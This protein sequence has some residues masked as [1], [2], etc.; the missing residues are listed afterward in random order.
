[1]SATFD[2]SQVAPWLYWSLFPIHR[3]FMRLY[4][5]QITVQGWEHLPRQGP[6]VFAVKHFSRWDPLVISLLSR[7]PLRYMTNANQFAGV[8]GWMIQRLGGFAVDIARPQ[9]SSLRH[10]VEL[11]HQRKKLVI[12]PEGGIVRDQLLR[13]LKPGLARLVLQAE[14]TAPEPLA[15]P[16]FPISLLY[17]PEDRRGAQ[18]FLQI[19]SALYTQ[20]YRQENEKQTAQA[21]TQAL[22]AALIHGLKANQ[23]TAIALNEA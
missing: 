10:T 5:G 18:I 11:L 4:F 19:T 20:D 17:Y 23:K 2:H 12:F 8:Q 15:V 1:M 16:I 13:S 6:A 7:E 3:L 9:L 14:T 22:E 21:L